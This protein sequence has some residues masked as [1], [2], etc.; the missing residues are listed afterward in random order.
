[1]EFVSNK[2]AYMAWCI[3]ITCQVHRVMQ[4]FVEG[5]LKNNPAIS[6]AFVRFLTRQTLANIAPGVGGQIKTL[7]DALATL[8]GSV[9]AAT[10]AAKE[11]TQAAKEAN[12]RAMTAANTKSDVAKN[13]LNALYSKNLTLKC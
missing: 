13:G 3:W 7:S 4:E 2:G 6:T 8:K 1:M 12:A 11:A 10:T 5:G 9:S